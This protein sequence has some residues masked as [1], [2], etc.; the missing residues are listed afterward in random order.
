VRWVLIFWPTRIV[1][2]EAGQQS[3][4]EVLTFSR[5]FAKVRNP[6]RSMMRRNIENSVYLLER[7]ADCLDEEQDQNAKQVARGSQVHGLCRRPFCYFK[8]VIILWCIWNWFCYHRM[9]RSEQDV[10]Q[11][12]L[13]TT[14]TLWIAMTSWDDQAGLHSALQ[15]VVEQVETGYNKV[16]VVVFEDKSSDMLT[17][18]QKRYYDYR[19]DVTFL[20]NTQANTTRGAAYAKWILFQWIQKRA[21][22]HEYVL[23]LD[24]D[25]TLADKWVLRDVH[26]ALQAKKPWFAW[27]KH[28]GKYSDQCQELSMN[29]G[30]TVRTAVWSFCHPR[31]FQ[32]HLLQYLEMKDFQRDDG[33]WLQKATDRPFIFRFMELA[34][35]R[36]LLYLG[37][38]PLYNY[39]MG[40]HNGLRIF[41]RKVIQGDKELVNR[42]VAASPAPD[43]IHVVTCVY[44]RRNT[45]TYLEQLANSNLASG[46]KLHIHICNNKS[47]R[48]AELEDLVAQINHRKKLKRLPIHQMDVHDMGT[49]QGGF[50]R[51]V[52]ARSIA[53]KHFVDYVIMVDDDQYVKRTTVE[54][55]YAE[56]EPRT[57]KTWYG[58]NWEPTQKSYWLQ[59]DKKLVYHPRLRSQFHPDVKEY[60]YGGTGMSIIDASVFMNQELFELEQQYLFVE[61]IWLSYIVQLMGWHIGRLFVKFDDAGKHFRQETGQFKDLSAV[62]EELFKKVGYLKCTKR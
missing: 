61:D 54:E 9:V 36:H 60:Q 41:D 43:V 52:L 30:E 15:S 40:V 44:H 12:Q 28:N 8:A 51:F 7:A 39:T 17:E 5:R 47:D 59:R 18:K 37:D 53:R 50:S 21:L 56:R 49:N 33:T 2:S 19:M 3:D 29:P 13:H 24:G 45:K 22:P 55:I 58:K 32:S 1:L 6:A 10:C 20:S 38:R 46:H 25:D 42:R 14:E 16:H 48:Q 57:Y 62:K 26:M 35:K 31:M 27:G 34:G 4:N 23:V 11:R